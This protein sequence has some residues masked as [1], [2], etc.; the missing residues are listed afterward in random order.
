MNSYYL[1]WL[2]ALVDADSGCAKTSYKC[3]CGTLHSIP[4]YST[5]EEDVNREQDGRKLRED[6]FN[7]TGRSVPPEHLCT[8]LEYLIGIAY[9]MD[10]IMDSDGLESNMTR[11]FW[12][13]IENAGLDL[14]VD[15]RYYETGAFEDV[16]E[17]CDIWLERRFKADG[18]GGFFPCPESGK[19]YHNECVRVMIWDYLKYHY[20]TEEEV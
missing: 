6:Y 10:Y 8:M 12:E 16:R 14:Y 11:W 7:E 5:V 15:H 1:D 3:L 18:R 13:I 19:D 17:I 2:I 9:R 20:Q 4:V